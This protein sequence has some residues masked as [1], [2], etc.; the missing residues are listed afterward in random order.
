MNARDFIG[1][2][3]GK[4]FMMHSS[5]TR[6]LESQQDDKMGEKNEAFMEKSSHGVAQV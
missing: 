5:A 2:P 3:Q 4:I 6:N 1:I